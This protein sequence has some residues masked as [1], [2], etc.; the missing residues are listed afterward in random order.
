MLPTRR[1]THSFSPQP[2]IWEY[3]RDCVDRYDIGRHFL[4]DCEVIEARWDAQGEQWSLDTSKGRIDAPVLI[5]AT[6][7]L[8]EPKVPDFEGIETFG[9]EI[10]HSAQWR[11]DVDL[12]GKRVAV[13]GTGASA[14]QFV[15][16]IQPL[17][18]HL[19]LYQRSAPWV[20]PR[21]DRSVS[22]FARALYARLP[23]TQKLSRLK[24][25]LFFESLVSVF[26]SQAS[27]R[28]ALMRKGGTEF[29]RAQIPDEAL[30][31]KLTPQFDPGCKRLLLSDD[32]YPAVNQP[33]VE[34]VTSPVAALGPSVV[35]DEQGT[36]READIVI[37]GTGFDAAEPPYAKRLVGRDGARLS[38]VWADGVEAYVGSTVAGFP[39]LFMI[40]G[41]NSTLAHNSMIYMI[42][43][44][45]HYVCDALDY[46]ARPGV[47][48]VEVR[49][50]V[51]R[52]YNEGLQKRFARTVW[53]RGGCT[54]WY[55]DHRGRNTTLW[56]RSTRA[57][58]KVTQH[59]H[60][61]DYEVRGHGRAAA[62]LK[63]SRLAP[64]AVDHAD[65]AFSPTVAAGEVANTPVAVS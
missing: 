56:P 60:P 55:L 41:P 40:I 52:R 8:S 64:T 38:D 31:Q 63:R 25:Y 51:Q 29:L 37:M 9:G 44:H 39:N 20:F 16:K 28:S 59:F 58:R 24:T 49:P 13:V 54:S 3:L 27:R 17:V 47:G 57:F 30:R 45:I 65:G 32:Y 21:K 7:S 26:T 46:L 5:W 34:L 23:L 61:G 14:I 43:S 11:H 42:E 35:V 22:K 50:D 19:T 2:E 36:I 53:V 15:P 62:A 33:N 6:G 1:W 12:T 48:T 10:F 18:A 4:Y